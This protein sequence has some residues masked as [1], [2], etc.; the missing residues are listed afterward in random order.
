MKVPH[1]IPICLLSCVVLLPA[2][3][4]G[5]TQGI[6]SVWQSD[7]AEAA[8]ALVLEAAADCSVCHTTIPALNPYGQDVN[9]FGFGWFGIEPLDSDGDGRTNG[10]EIRIDCSL[11]GDATS[12]TA[13]TTWS[14]IRA[15]YKD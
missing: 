12:P 6:A 7:Y 9:D 2:G 14:R 1:V 5:A 15:L 3:P 8:C 11:P 10:E 4:A 13:A